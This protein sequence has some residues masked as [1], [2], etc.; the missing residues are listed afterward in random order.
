[1]IVTTLGALF[2]QLFSKTGYIFGDK[3]IALAVISIVLVVFA[4][5]VFFEVIGK[6]VR[7][8]K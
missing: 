3:N 5:I 8:K 1:M 2:Y 4:L 7:R 6:L